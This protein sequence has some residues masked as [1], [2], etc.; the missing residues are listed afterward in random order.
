MNKV[1]FIVG[2]RG[3]G[4]SRNLSAI[5]SFLNY[6]CSID[7][8]HLNTRSI[9]DFICKELN[10][11]FPPGRDGHVVV[12]TSNQLPH[13]VERLSRLLQ[14]M[15]SE[16]TNTPLTVEVRAFSQV[17]LDMA[18]EARRVE[19]GWPTPLIMF[20]GSTVTPA[21]PAK[22]IP[23]P[24][25]F[26]INAD[27][28]TDTEAFR[29]LAKKMASQGAE[30]AIKATKLVAGRYADGFE[31]NIRRIIKEVLSEQSKTAKPDP[32]L[33][34]TKYE[35]GQ[36]AEEAF[37]AALFRVNEYFDAPVAE[38][39]LLSFGYTTPEQ[40]PP[41]KKFTVARNLNTA[42]RTAKAAGNGA[43]CDL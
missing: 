18:I 2:K 35:Y 37:R 43:G 36:K 14:K 20:P 34:P 40:V 23:P 32:A 11:E 16:A 5:A 7:R 26:E 19:L 38:Y 29:A 42:L 21:P 1:I 8:D 3:C 12:V 24:L 41:R 33:K 10:R 39:V 25:V 28:D 6:T 31:A 17:M 30:Y 4:K 22:P 15:Q 9:A 27:I 13:T